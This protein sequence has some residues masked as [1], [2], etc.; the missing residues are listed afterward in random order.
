[1]ELYNPCE[2]QIFINKSDDGVLKDFNFINTKG[3][4]KSINTNDLVKKGKLNDSI[5]SSSSSQS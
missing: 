4:E 1:M 3:L 5:S 2:K